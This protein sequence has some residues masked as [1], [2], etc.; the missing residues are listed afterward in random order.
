MKKNVL[1]LMLFAF[2]AMVGAKAQT[3]VYDWNFS[4]E[5]WQP[6]ASD[7][8][9][10]GYFSDGT[11]V[12]FLTFH[13]PTSATNFAVNAN[14]KTVDGVDYSVRF[15]FNGAGYSGAANTDV[16]PSNNMPTQRYLSF[17]VD[18]PV[19][20]DVVAITGSGSSP[21]AIFL[22]DGT[23]LIGTFSCPGDN[24]AYKNTVSY[25]GDAATLYLFCNAS[26]NI[27]EIIVTSNSE[28]GIPSVN[29]D[30]P[31]K[32]A[33]YFDILG[34]KVVDTNQKNVVLIKKTTYTDG[35]TSTEKVITRTY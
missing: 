21:R 31:V 17:D 27:Y 2:L 6:Y 26:C 5:I 1:F 29:A 25:T 8:T 10:T 14:P 19:T 20:V 32:S 13:N 24:T 30:K 3:V 9:P 22:T 23:D 12:D 7:G 28:S 11:V 34:R 35:T 4:D 18:G 15:Q 33:E 16:T